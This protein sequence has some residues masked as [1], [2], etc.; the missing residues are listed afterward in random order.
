VMLEVMHRW[1]APAI[2]VPCGC[3]VSA[4]RCTLAHKFARQWCSYLCACLQTSIK[5]FASQK[6]ADMVSAAGIITVMISTFDQSRQVGQG[7]CVGW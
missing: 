5:I 3:Y 7:V 6:P 4:Y 2:R 1:S